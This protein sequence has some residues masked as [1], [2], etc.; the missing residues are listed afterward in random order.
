MKH[1]KK[2]TSSQRHIKHV[3]NLVLIDLEEHCV[4]Y[5]AWWLGRVQG[6]FSLRQPINSVLEGG[7]ETCCQGNS[8]IQLCLERLQ[9]NGNSIN[10]S[11]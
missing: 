6:L 1:L 11:A 8:L 3:Q 5:E 4:Q 9:I 2:T 10:T 7:L